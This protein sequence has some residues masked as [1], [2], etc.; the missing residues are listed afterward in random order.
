M[1]W[2]VTALGWE[3]ESI[4]SLNKLKPSVFKRFNNES[5]KNAILHFKKYGH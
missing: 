3:T 5:E 2:F 1:N 4:W